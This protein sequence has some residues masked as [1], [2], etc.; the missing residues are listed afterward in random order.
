[1]EN[2]AAPAPLRLVVY[3][4]T[5]IGVGPWPGL[6]HSWIAGGLLY[7][8]R[9]QIDLVFGA[10]DWMEALS[11]LA[12]VEPARRIAEIQY[13]GHGK[14]GQIHIDRQ[15]LN[16]RALLANHAHAS[17]LNRIRERLVGPHA[18][19]WLRTCETF[20]AEKGHSFAAAL[21]ERMGCKVAG[22]TYIIGPFQSGL[23]SL[24]P[25]QRAQWSADEGIREGTAQAPR[26][27]FWSTP[28]APHTI[29]CLQGQIPR[30]Y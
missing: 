8:L 24:Q 7:R 11:W 12:S 9:N 10:A 30:A 29:H 25:G 15:A 20:G 19:L 17:L 22:H 21:A 3:D 27:A 16:E 23:H 14:W 28:W 6:T 13:W 2:S 5:C 4:R 26:R 18:L 1:M